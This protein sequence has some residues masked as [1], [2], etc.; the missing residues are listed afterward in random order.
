M[1]PVVT[2][3]S[4]SRTQRP[5]RRRRRGA[6]PR[7]HERAGDVGRAVASIEV[8]LGD[9]RALAASSSVAYGSPRWRGRG[10]RDELRLVVAPRPARSAWTGTCVTTSAPTPTRAQRRA[11]GRTEGLGEPLLAAVLDR[12]E[13]GADRAAERCAPVEL[14]ERRRDIARAARSGRRPAPRAARSR[15]GTQASHSGG[16]SRPHPTQAAGRARRARWRPCARTRSITR[17]EDD[18]S[19]LIGDLPR[20][21]RPGGP[22]PRL[23]SRMPSI[24]P[25]GSSRTP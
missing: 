25:T 2:T 18:G 22:G 4:T 9:R 13:G 1:A 5:M 10:P 15:A 11:I 6:R 8:E 14:Q 19:R 23:R 17:A 24:V 3:S 16:P 20:G 12:V 21:V 7:T